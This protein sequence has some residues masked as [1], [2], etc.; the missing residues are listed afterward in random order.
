VRAERSRSYDFGVQQSLTDRGLLSVTLFHN[1][2]YDQIEFLGTSALQQLGV[3]ADAINAAGFGATVNTLN[4]LAKGVETELQ[5]K[6]TNALQARGGYTY[7]DARVQRSFSS[8]ALAPAINPAFPGIPIGAFSPLIGARPFRRAPHTGFVAVTYNRPRW[9]AL[10]QGVFVGPRDDSTFLLDADF[11]NT[12]LLPNRNL[13]SAYQKLD[14][15]GDYR[16]NQHLLVFASMENLL[17]ERYSSNFGFP[18]LPFTV[19]SGVK[20]TIGGR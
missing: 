5:F 16:F 9:S 2:F 1:Q 11:G 8:D 19:R 17:N 13:N 12:L 10:L 3:P 7:L 20:I 14:L 15:S 18:A 4:F 6:I